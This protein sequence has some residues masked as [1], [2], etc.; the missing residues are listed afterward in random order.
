MID[1]TNTTLYK[2]YFDVY[3]H[4]LSGL[5]YVKPTNNKS[6][7][8]VFLTEVGMKFFD[9][10]IFKDTYKIHYAVEYLDKKILW[11]LL[12]NDF[13]S[14]LTNTLIEKKIC[15]PTKKEFLHHRK[16]RTYYYINSENQFEKIEK[17]S[18]FR[19]KMFVYLRDYQENFPFEIEIEHKN[20]DVN[21][22]LIKIKR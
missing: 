4:H 19:V 9:I 3:K 11:K 22:K 1:S 6:Y 10:E 14:L 16:E 18:R 5:L 17:R 7:R 12:Q 13:N 15:V 21:I 2:A 8:V 20:I